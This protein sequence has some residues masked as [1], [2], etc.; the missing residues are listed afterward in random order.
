MHDF[1]RALDEVKPLFGVSEQD[2]ARAV[3]G[4]IIKFSPHIERI[5]ATGRDFVNQVKS[6][7]TPLLSVL[8]HGPP[9]AGKTALAARIAIDSEFP[10]IKLVRPFDMAGMNEMQKIQYLQKVFTDAYK[11]PSSLLVLDDVDKIFDWNY[12]GPR[13]SASLLG[14]MD[15]FIRN[16]PPLGRPL[17]IFA[18][19]SR[20]T[21][22]KQ[23]ELAFDENIA[24]PNV[25]SQAE[26]A[27]IMQSSGAFSQAEIQKS[28]AGIEDTVS[29]TGIG[30]GVKQVI[31]AIQRLQKAGEGV[32][33]A[34]FFTAIMAERINEA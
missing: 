3:E 34:E 21:V 5:L 16:K 14:A 32:D 19:T 15:S 13:F 27:Q 1:L 10:F 2:L 11:S 29:G 20:R 24:V 4:G 7:T 12:T 9:G 31:T 18:T 33:K 8:I 28:I 30:V 26:L 17:L 22:L 25:N 23:V 6:N